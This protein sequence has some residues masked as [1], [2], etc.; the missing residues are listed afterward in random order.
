MGLV[1]VCA[2]IS[3]HVQTT[4]VQNEITYETLKR[5]NYL[6]AVVQETLRYY[7]VAPKFAISKKFHFIRWLR[8]SV[9]EKFQSESCV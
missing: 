1:F 8:E 7:P 6:Q 5:M 2:L 4:I 3:D 9:R